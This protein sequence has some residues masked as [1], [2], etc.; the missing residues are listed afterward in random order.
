[1]LRF[2]LGGAQGPGAV[3]GEGA[4]GQQ[5]ALA[6]IITAVTRWTKVGGFG[7]HHGGAYPVGGGGGGHLHFVEVG[8]GLIH[9]MVVL[10]DDGIALLAVRSSGWPS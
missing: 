9:R 7:G 4:D 5:V 3:D 10:L 1:M 6:S 8:Q 2:P